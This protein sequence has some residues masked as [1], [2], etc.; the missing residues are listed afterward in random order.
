LSTTNREQAVAF[1]EEKFKRA[2]FGFPKLIGWPES[3][4]LDRCTAPAPG[5]ISDLFIAAFHLHF[6][7]LIR[8][9]KK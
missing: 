9:A 1:Y 5:R 3:V 7:M 6:G 4:L 8:E 2:W